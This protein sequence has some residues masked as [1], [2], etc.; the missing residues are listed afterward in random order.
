MPLNASKYIAFCGYPAKSIKYILI[1]KYI[2][3]WAQDIFLNFHHVYAKIYCYCI[4]KEQA[5]SFANFLEKEL[6][7]ANCFDM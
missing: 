7:F 6:T 1:I 2:S 5:L 3:P 4:F